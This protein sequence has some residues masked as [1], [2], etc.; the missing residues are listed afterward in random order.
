MVEMDPENTVLPDEYHLS[1]TGVPNLDQ[2]RPDLNQERF[3]DVHS[4]LFH[5]IRKASGPE[6]QYVT[7]TSKTAADGFL[8]PFRLQNCYGLSV[9]MIHLIRDGRATLWSKY[10]KDR[11]MNQGIFS[12]D[13][14]GFE[15]FLSHPALRTGL[16]WPF[17][18]LT[19]RLFSFCYPSQYIQVRYEDFTNN[20]L[21]ELDRISNFLDVSLSLP[22]KLVRNNEPIPKSH[23]ISGNRLR[24][25]D[26]LRLHEDRQSWKDHLTDPQ[27]LLYK[28]LGGFIIHLYGY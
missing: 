18:N 6:T 8:R 11:K 1:D 7:D 5:A 21:H 12:P 3:Q 23:Q 22:K 24:R 28:V 27:L 13:Y 10:K 25:K 20:S 26:N 17:A 16:H 9:R 2:I 19:A 14:S 15:R 4:R